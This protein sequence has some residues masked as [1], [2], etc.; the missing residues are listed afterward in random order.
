MYEHRTIIRKNIKKY[1]GLC[2]SY[3]KPYSRETEI[4]FED[5][6][7]D[8]F[9]F[10]PHISKSSLGLEVG[11]MGGILAFSIKDIFKLKKLYTIEH[12]VI[13]QQYTKKF[14]N[15]LKDNNIILKSSDLRLAKLPF[16]SNYFDFIILSEVLEHLIPSDIP[17]L[18]L[19]LKRVL[20]RN[21]WILITTP[22]ITSLIKRTNTIRGKNPVVFDMELHHN[23]VFGHI[24][25]YT[26]YELEKIVADS[27]LKIIA[28]HY[29]M[30]DVK[31]NIFTRIEKLVSIFLPSLS[32][33]LLI[34]A[35]K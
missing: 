17:K 3:A 20:K 8:M 12:P 23:A 5:R 16:K 32:N 13:C 29:F 11:L 19:E 10:L 9:K 21:G 4:F 33:N 28:K 15:T 26:M 18:I 31:R 25:E 35:I 34:R 24:R 6:Y 22:N 30:L 27:G 2:F 7:T 1:G 14:L